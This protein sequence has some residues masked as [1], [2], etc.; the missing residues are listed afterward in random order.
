MAEKTP[1][2]VVLEDYDVSAKVLIIGDS[3]V[4]KSCILVRYINGNF[5]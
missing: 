2:K 3:K 4:G 1:K 5:P